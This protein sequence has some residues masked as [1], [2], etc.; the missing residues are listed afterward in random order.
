[1]KT[2]RWFVINGAVA[3]LAYFGFIQGLDGAANVAMVILWL[4]I[5]LSPF[6]LMDKLADELRSR[7][8]WF[9]AVDTVYDITMT[10]FL[11]WIGMMWTGVFYLIHTML[12]AGA[13]YSTRNN[14]ED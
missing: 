6:V 9:K 2:L 1:M 8:E 14:D 7:P 5:A 11:L 3:C 13:R 4:T 12:V 10:V